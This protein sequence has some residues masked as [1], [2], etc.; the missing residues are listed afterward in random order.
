VIELPFIV[1][2]AAVNVTFNREVVLM[3]QIDPFVDFTPSRPAAR[4]GENTPNVELEALFRV[5]GFCEP[6]WVSGFGATYETSPRG[7]G[8]L[9]S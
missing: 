4:S 6:A 3:P 9:H 7:A 1:V 2:I 5:H 8:C